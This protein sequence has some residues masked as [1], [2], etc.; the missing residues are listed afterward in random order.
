[1]GFQPLLFFFTTTS[2]RSQLCS[3]PFVSSAALTNAKRTLSFDILD[4][5]KTNPHPKSP[6][7]GYPAIKEGL[8]AQSR[9]ELEKLYDD[10]WRAVAEAPSKKTE[11]T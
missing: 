7:F 9:V 11:E 4:F 1:L 6:W 10:Y 2:K 5:S 8:P 3:L